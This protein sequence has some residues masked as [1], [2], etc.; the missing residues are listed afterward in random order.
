LIQQELSR[1]S[2]CVKI[3][4]YDTNHQSNYALQ[5]REDVIYPDAVVEGTTITAAAPVTKLLDINGKLV[6]GDAWGAIR[7]Y[8]LS[9]SQGSSEESNNNNAISRR[10]CAFL[11]FG[12]GSSSIACMEQVVG[13]HVL[14]AVS[15]EPAVERDSNSRMVYPL[16]T[17]FRVP[18]PR[19][20]YIVDT[21]EST[22]KAVLDNVHNDTVRGMCSLP[23]GGLLTAGGKMDATV[24]V[25]DSFDF[26]N[27]SPLVKEDLDGATDE[28]QVVTNSKILDQPG[29]V[30]DLKVL[31]DSNGSG[32]YAVAA[33]RYNVIKIVI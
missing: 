16:A 20:V 25:W 26:D 28:M 4:Y 32:V 9:S 5:L 8:E 19:G 27:A 29:Y 11:Q 30:F 18:S 12:G 1:V 14:L 31:P 23:D 21:M 3:W 22:V 17:S 2:S 15:I 6:C 10:Q 33:A 24:R 7:I 13:K